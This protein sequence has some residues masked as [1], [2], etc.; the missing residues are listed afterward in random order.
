MMAFVLA[1]ERPIYDWL[2]DLEEWTRKSPRF[3]VDRL[4][5][6]DLAAVTLS[7]PAV[8][9]VIAELSKRGVTVM[10]IEGADPSLYSSKLPPVL[11]NPPGTDGETADPSLP[12]TPDVLPEP[13][14]KPASLVMD[15]P[16]RSGQSVIFPDGDVTVLGSVGSGAE[17]MAGGSIHVY[18]TLRGRAAAGFKGNRG[19]RIFCSRNEAEILSIA[20]HYR[21]ADTMDGL[22]GQPVQAWLDGDEVRVAALE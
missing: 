6:L 16:V 14:R 18:G 22:R 19:A 21:T 17:I 3:F 9:H 13:E 10:A 15:R 12:A 20:G 1:P 7:E 8:G 2:C 4:V 11:S 5:I